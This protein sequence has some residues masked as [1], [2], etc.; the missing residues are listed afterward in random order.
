V[1]VTV[2]PLGKTAPPPPD[3]TPPADVGAV[4]A[5][6]GNH[7]V[8]LD[9]RMPATDV[10]AVEVRMSTAG[11]AA[12]RVVYRG[13]A[14]RAVVQKLRN[15]TQ[16]RFVLVSLDES[17]NRSKGVV[18]VAAPKALLLAV[19]KPGAKV[20]TPPLLRW[21][22]VTGVRYYNVQLYRG[23]VKVLSAW[24]AGA[25]LQLKKAWTYDRVKRKLGPGAYTWYVWPGLGRRD[26]ARYG[27][28]LGS[29]SFVVVAPG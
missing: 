13:T 5:T 17:G 22:P 3:L 15:D 27:P 19:P 24:P 21:V 16:Y 20:R 28:L 6:P 10:A 9:W 29:S 25:K 11:G 18:V 14:S 2:L 23:K 8:T 7:R 1:R 12:D 4:R 26:E